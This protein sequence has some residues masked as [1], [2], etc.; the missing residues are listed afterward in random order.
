MRS[1]LI[2]LFSLISQVGLA[3][4][5]S[6]Y[7]DGTRS[8]SAFTSR[9]ID[10]LEELIHISI[11]QDFRRAT[12]RVE[13]L[14]HTDTAG[15]QIPLLFLAEDYEEDFK[16]W[17][18]G[19]RVLI[20]DI[21]PD[22][23]M[24]SDSLTTQFANSF[25]SS[26]DR[27]ETRV[28]HWQK[29]WGSTHYLQEL[30]YF[31]VDLTKGQHRIRVEYEASAWRDISD[32]V[33]KY[34]FRYALAPAK[35]WRSFGKLEIQLDA[36]AVG[37]PI[38]T[39]LGKPHRGNLREI[40]SWTFSSLPADYIEINHQPKISTF[41]GFLI[42]IGPFGLTLGFAVLLTLLHIWGI[43]RFRKRYPARRY[44]WVVIVGSFLVPL[45][46]FLFYMESYALI[47][48]AIGPAAGGYHGYIFLVIIFYPVVLLF[49]WLIMRWV[50]RR[51]KQN[52]QQE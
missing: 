44:S 37:E 47:D 1:L 25:Q 51:L 20:L 10:V 40:A 45:L 6:P 4:M 31:E 36:A 42:V 9:D 41:A 43:R 28:I 3:N 29:N 48:A 24:I 19:N 46:S 21:P 23:Q 17:V 16:V 38:S 26:N 50:D 7:L 11:D 35:Y 12:Y 13:Y 8:A 15:L 52:L 14:I 39:N 5:A 34:S 2:F 30:K 33:T 27:T 49:Y 32:W 22:Y 18:D